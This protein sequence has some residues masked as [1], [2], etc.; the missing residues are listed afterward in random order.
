MYF[1]QETYATKG[2]VDVVESYATCVYC[3]NC[4]NELHYCDI[5]IFIIA[6]PYYICDLI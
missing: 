1:K 6:Q 2:M 4:N 5:T 3:G